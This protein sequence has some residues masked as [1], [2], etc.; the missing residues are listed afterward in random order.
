[1]AAEMAAQQARHHTT[2]GMEKEL[3]SEYWLLSLSQNCSLGSRC[4]TPGQYGESID[5]GH[6]MGR[7]LFLVTF[8]S[9]RH[10]LLRREVG[11]Q[12]VFVYY[13]VVGNT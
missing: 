10:Y 9:L 3:R 5:S 11:H 8:P 6:S 2:N 12:E 13:M 7:I 1:V 4:L